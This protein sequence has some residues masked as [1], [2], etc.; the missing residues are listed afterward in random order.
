MPEWMTIIAALVALAG[1]IFGVVNGYRSMKR[2]SPLDEVRREN[3]EQWKK[4]Y[5]VKWDKMVD[6]MERVEDTVRHVDSE[7]TRKRFEELEG[8]LKRN[9]RQI[10]AIAD[11]TKNQ[12]RFLLLLLR[13][14]QQSLNH[15]S[16]GNHAKELKEV[17][18]EINDFLLSE[19]TRCNL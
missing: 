17:S 12:Q 11:T 9:D 3:T 14:Q 2:S 1:G 16:D 7:Q 13:A 6:R 19:A 15:L 5:D 4:F 18:N 10:E 8:K